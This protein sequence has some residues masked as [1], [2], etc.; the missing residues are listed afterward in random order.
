MSKRVCSVVNVVGSS[1]TRYS[2]HVII[3]TAGPEVA[4]ASQKA[5]CTQVTALTNVALKIAEI[6]GT[7]SAE[8]LPKYKEALL[9]TAVVGEKILEQEE[10]IKVVAEAIR[11]KH[12]FYFLARGVSIAAAFIRY[13]KRVHQRVF[14]ECGENASL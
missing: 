3:T 11:K 1:L 14:S 5:Y 8:E 13:L 12:S 7:I 4:V 6:K 9:N 10:D 2:D